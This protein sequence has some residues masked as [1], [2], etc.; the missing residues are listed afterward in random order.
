MDSQICQLPKELFIHHIFEYLSEKSKRNLRQTCKYINHIWC[1]THGITISS[2]NLTFFSQ[3]ITTHTGWES[4]IHTLYVNIL[5]SKQYKP[6]LFQHVKKIVIC[7]VLHAYT[8]FNHN[9]V[10]LFKSYTFPSLVSLS[11]RI[12]ESLSDCI[13]RT[14]LELQLTGNIYFTCRL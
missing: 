10:D 2:D 7:S 4:R 1:I 11:T 5:P 3:Y 13:P 6:F 8:L 9:C 14:L 12:N